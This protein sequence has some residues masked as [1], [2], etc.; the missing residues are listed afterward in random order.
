MRSLEGGLQVGDLAR[1]RQALDGLDR[2]AVALH[3]QHQAAAHDL[4]V[5][6]YRAGAAHAVLAADMAS[7]QRQ[8]LAQEIDQRLARFD[9]LADALAVDGEGNVEGEVAHARASSQLLGDAP[10]QYAGEV[11]LHRPGRLHVVGRIEIERG[12]RGIDIAGRQRR[13]GF[14][15][16]HRRGADAEIGQPHVGKPLAVGARAGGQ[17]DD[18]VIAV[19]ARQLG[20]ADARVFARGRDAHRGEHFL[21]PQRRLEQSLEESV[22]LHLALAFGAGDF[23]LSPEREQAGGQFRRRIGEGD[24]AAEGAAVANGGMPDMRHGERDQRRV[25]GD[26]LGTL[27]LG[28]AR[29]GA[30]LDEFALF[31]DAVEA[32]DAVDVDQQV[33][34][35]QP[36]VERGNQALPAG[37]QP[38]I[39]LMLGQQR[40]R[41]LERAR[42]GVGEWRRLH[43]SP[44]I[45]LARD[46]VRKPV[47]IPD[48]V[49]DML[50]GI[51]RRFFLL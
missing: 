21:R 14:G 4:A 47:P 40:N 38:R 7:G 42:L 9:A 1:I 2:G 49:E 46:L 10:Q 31:G 37:Q 36:H 34:R 48:Q 20:K 22:G 39:V 44:N 43:V 11:F 3:G 13:F 33:R 45:S 35:R 25:P 16:A 32:L 29:Q 27:D 17:A 41:F 15:R 8:I 28:M 51:T 6:P 26:Q 23:D 18:G 19:P 24:G 30:D 50:F 12:D 5:H